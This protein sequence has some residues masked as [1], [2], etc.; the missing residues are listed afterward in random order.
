[1]AGESVL[2]RCHLA[3]TFKGFHVSEVDAADFDS[4]PMAVAASLCS[5]PSILLG[6]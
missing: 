4:G 6:C 5:G 2:H 3:A 1:M